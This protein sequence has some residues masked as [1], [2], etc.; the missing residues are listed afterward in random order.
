MPHDAFDRWVDVPFVHIH[1][2]ISVL[3]LGAGDGGDCL[4]NRKQ[5][6]GSEVSVDL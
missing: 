2:V 1:R 6:A 5:K 3:H 4:L